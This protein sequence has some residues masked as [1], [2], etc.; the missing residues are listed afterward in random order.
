MQKP[1]RDAVGAEPSYGHRQLSR[2]GYFYPI[3]W[4]NQEE[5]SLD[6]LR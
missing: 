2:K 6:A 3:L 1:Q 5:K 4:E